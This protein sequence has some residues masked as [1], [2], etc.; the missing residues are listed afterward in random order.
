MPAALLTMAVRINVLLQVLFFIHQWQVAPFWLLPWPNYLTMVTLVPV[1][2]RVGGQQTHSRLTPFGQK[3][4]YAKHITN[5]K[6]SM[7]EH[8]D[9]TFMLCSVVHAYSE[10]VLPSQHARF[11]RACATEYVPCCARTRSGGSRG[12]GVQGVWTP[13]LEPEYEYN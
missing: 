4:N 8:S 10:A 1:T 2:L 3:I 13:P 5:W 9:R 7:R 11:L 6:L 12:G